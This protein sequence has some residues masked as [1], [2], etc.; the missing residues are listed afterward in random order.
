MATRTSAGERL[1]VEVLVAGDDDAFASSVESEED[2]VGTA[3]NVQKIQL[4][5]IETKVDEDE[6]SSER[7]RLRTGRPEPHPESHD[8]IDNTDLQRQQKRFGKKRKTV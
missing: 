1:P 2:Q 8:R 4:G 6:E 7:A 3:S 5:N